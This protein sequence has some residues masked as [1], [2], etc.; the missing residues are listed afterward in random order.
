MI[1]RKSMTH[2]ERV[3][4]RIKH[5]YVLHNVGH[6]AV[7][8][9]GCGWA[10][11]RDHPIHDKPWGTPVTEDDIAAW[12][13]KKGE[14]P[15]PAD[16]LRE[17]HNQGL[18]G[19]D[20]VSFGKFDV[21]FAVKH[22]ALNFDPAESDHAVMERMLRRERVTPDLKQT[23]RNYLAQAAAA[24]EIARKDPIMQ[25]PDPITTTM[26]QHD[27]KFVAQLGL[28]DDGGVYGVGQTY[29]VAV[30]AALKL[31]R[32][33]Q[34]EPTETHESSPTTL[35]R[36]VAVTPDEIETMLSQHMDER[37]N[38]LYKGDKDDYA[39]WRTITPHGINRGVNTYVPS[40][41]H[42]ESAPRSFRLDRIQRVQVTD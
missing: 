23:S 14:G 8:C 17:A 1:S 28:G 32:S 22:S 20:A 37:V 31:A 42:Y 24:V 19:P 3:A 13:A 38:I 9:Y 35:R 27:G 12:L 33:V 2:A 39:K 18:Y 7:E 15:L 21:D 30:A 5:P 4:G 6:E 26:G 11:E 29:E 10:F 34:P 25:L 40:F 36:R 41:C 16:K